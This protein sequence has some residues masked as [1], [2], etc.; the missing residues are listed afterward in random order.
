MARIGPDTFGAQHLAENN[1][2]KYRL[3][4]KGASHSST[5]RVASITLNGVN[6]NKTALTRGLNLVVIDASTMTVVEQ[7]A[8]DIFQN[9]EHRTTFQTYISELP[10]NRIVAIASYDALRS[11]PELD[12]FMASIGS[13]CWLGN[14]YMNRPDPN[15]NPGNLYFYRSAYSAIYNSTMKKIV[16]E[17]A[18]GA[19]SSST[20]DNRTTTDI[21]FDT[22]DDVGATGIPFRIVDDDKEYENSGTAYAFK[23]YVSQRALAD[24]KLKANDIIYVTAEMFVS[25][26][27]LD[28]G[29]YGQMHVEGYTSGEWKWGAPSPTVRVANVWTPIQYWVTIKPCEGISIGAY[30]MPSSVTT[31][32][33][34]V[35]NAMVTQV[36]RTEK[37]SGNA[38]FGV[39]GIRATK[40]SEPAGFDN[41][42]MQLLNIPTDASNKVITSNKFSEVS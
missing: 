39:N 1:S 36:S 40:L 7:R 27:A 26:E 9:V 42:I 24:L 22:I 33:I 32:T 6:I 37:T 28:A 34:K 35:R 10:A 4:V 41:P 38:G 29:A 20:E 23:L 30:H 3:T 18:N 25:Q 12:A 8:F 11:S 14:A 17:D 21:V 31:G 13:T 2:V 19:V 16:M 15:P 5:N